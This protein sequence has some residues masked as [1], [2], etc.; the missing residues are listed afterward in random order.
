MTPTLIGQDQ[1]STGVF[2]Y[3]PAL[4]DLKVERFFPDRNH[5]RWGQAALTVQGKIGDFDLVYA[6]G[7]FDRSLQSQSDYSDY[8]YAYSAYS[9]PSFPAFFKNAAGQAIDP[10]QHQADRDH[11]TKQTHDLRISSPS[12]DQFRFVAGIFYERQTHKIEQNYEVTGL[13]PDESVTGWPGTYWLTKE[14]RVDRDYAGL[15]SGHLRHHRPM[16][17]YG[18]HPRVQGA[19]HALRLLRLRPWEL[20]RLRGPAWGH[21]SSPRRSTMRR[22]STS[23]N[24]SRKPTP[25]SRPT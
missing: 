21:A 5:D 16:G 14:L 19:Q 18:R 25:R 10:S 17:D 1:R 9:G 13:G 24:R 3:N 22:A 2:G 8:T 20:L 7:Y 11:F 4:G 15:R 6:T 23:T 12:D